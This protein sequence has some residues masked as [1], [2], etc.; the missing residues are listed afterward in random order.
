MGPGQVGGR[1]RE[2]AAKIRRLTSAATKTNS[3]LQRVLEF[4]EVIA[5]LERSTR[6]MQ[7]VGATGLP[8][9]CVKSNAMF[10][11]PSELPAQLTIVSSFFK[12]EAHYLEILK[13][14]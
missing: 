8:V 7:S 1:R 12:R 11:G 10:V 5:K 13:D 3:L 14:G 2:F 6:R 9:V 4:G